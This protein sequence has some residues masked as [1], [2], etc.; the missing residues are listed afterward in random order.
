MCENSC[1][2]FIQNNKVFQ[3]SAS[4]SKH[5]CPMCRR[6]QNKPVLKVKGVTWKCSSDFVLNLENKLFCC[7]LN[8]QT[9]VA[10]AHIALGPRTRS[11]LIPVW[12]LWLDS[13]VHSWVMVDPQIII[14]ET[15]FVNFTRNPWCTLKQTHETPFVN[16]TRNPLG[17]LKQRPKYYKLLFWSQLTLLDKTCFVKARSVSETLS[18]QTWNNAFHVGDFPEVI[19]IILRRKESMASQ[20]TAIWMHSDFKGNV[21]VPL[22]CV[23]CINQTL[24]SYY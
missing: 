15:Q 7:V 3:E 6:D 11:S 4:E 17:T 21:P 22:C 12:P 1:S 13:I 19:I 16:F 2:V 9:C 20:R 24:P 10:W 5:V 18:Q 14:Q 8:E 23:W